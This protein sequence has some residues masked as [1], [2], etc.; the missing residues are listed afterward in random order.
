MTDLVVFGY[1]G[2]AAAA[3]D[4]ACCD[5]D[6]GCC[7]PTPM[8]VAEKVAKYVEAKFPGAYRVKYVDTFSLDAFDYGDVIQAIQDQNLSLP[9]VAMD[10]QV[11]VAGEFT[12][13]DLSGA[14]E[15]VAKA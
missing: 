6:S 1:S 15:G 11:L 7:G 14:L 9:V 12:M 2:G 8:Q 5:P 13:G 3:T 10:G 4:D